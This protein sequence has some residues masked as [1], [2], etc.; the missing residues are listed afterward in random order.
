[1]KRTIKI[2]QHDNYDCGAACLSSVAAWYGVKVPLAKVRRLCGCTKEGIT[3]KGILDGGKELGL[4]GKAYKS[5]NKDL[6]ALIKIQT[7]LIAHMK[8]E[9]GFFHFVTIYKITKDTVSIMDPADGQ[10]QKI[11]HSRFL[12]EWSGYIILLVPGCKFKKRDEKIGIYPRLFSLLSFHK[13]EIILSFAGSAALVLI[14]VSNSLFLQQIIDK[15]IPERNSTLLITISGILVALLLLSLYISYARNIYL[16][17]NGIKIDTRLIITYVRKLFTLP[18]DFFNQYSAGDL[19][20]RIGDAFKIRLFISEG[21]ISAFISVATLTVTLVLMY[22]YYAKLAILTSLFIPL[23]AGLYFLSGY[24]NKKYNREL[25]VTGARFEADVLNGME[26]MVS[27]KHYGAENLSVERIEGTYTDLVHKMY[28]AGRA[29]TLFG[30]AGDGLSR[31]LLTATLI[32][33]GFSVFGMQLT[34]GELVSFYTLCAFFTSP[35]NNLVNL[36][37]TITQAAVSSER[38]FEIIDLEDEAQELD[39]AHYPLPA[40]GQNLTIQNLTYSYPGRNTLFKDLN[41]QIENN[42]ITAFIGESGCGKSTLGA[43]LMR[44]FI[45]KQGDIFIG[46]RN[47]RSIPIKE[48]RNYISIVPQKCHLFNGSLLEN[49][50]CGETEPDIERVIQ[51]C[52]ELGMDSFI[53]RLPSGL[54][55]NVGENGST[56]SGGEMQKISVARVLY[57]NPQIIIFDEATSSMDKESEIYILHKINELKQIG[58]TIIMITHNLANTKY[59]DKVIN[60]STLNESYK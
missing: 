18:M 46:N 8:K 22:I 15:A 42:S 57:K 51:I 16:I 41:I 7:P 45:A 20:A 56:L 17:R 4:S 53:K 54:L 13:K 52:A 23:Y 37:N 50:T 60:I 34:V 1:M 29:A 3:I 38:L 9:N 25:A 35:L 28:Q 59:A 32:I 10:M 27:V 24:I 6:Q 2:Q 44:D 36:N 11:P 5:E 12:E 43:L 47:I 40:Q 31:V 55:T 49:I 26:S 19:N 33:G 58:K 14:G 48:W 21:L 39:S 30:I